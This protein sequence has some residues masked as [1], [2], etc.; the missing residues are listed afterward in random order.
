MVISRWNEIY[1]DMGIL[2]NMEYVKN[3]W[4]QA[5]KA[6]DFKYLE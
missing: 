1:W 5:E 3:I 6:W 2:E 4:E